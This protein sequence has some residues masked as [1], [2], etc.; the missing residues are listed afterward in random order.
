MV[1][2]EKEPW[3]GS[4]SAGR[5]SWAE[6]GLS[7]RGYQA[8]VLAGRPRRGRYGGV[9][10]KWRSVPAQRWRGLYLAVRPDTPA[11][12]AVTRHAQAGDCRR[13]VIVTGG[14]CANRHGPLQTMLRADVQTAIMASRSCSGETGLYSTGIFA[15]MI[16]RRRS[17]RVSPV[18]RRRAKGRSPSPLS[19]SS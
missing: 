1:A 14:G 2:A 15:A 7:P 17:L 11:G 3:R 6:Y 4:H 19:L 9:R 12:R 16:S 13:L 18:I 8:P 10:A 5:R